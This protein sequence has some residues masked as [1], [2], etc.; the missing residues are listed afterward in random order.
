MSGLTF[1]P[2]WA[3]GNLFTDKRIVA[4]EERLVRPWPPAFAATPPSTAGTSATRSTS[5]WT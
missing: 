3:D 4:G 2:P 5:S 1:L